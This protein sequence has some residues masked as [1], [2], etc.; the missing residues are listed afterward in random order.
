MPTNIPGATNQ[1]LHGVSHAFMIAI[2]VLILGVVA[3]FFF[4]HRVAP[5]PAYNPK[6]FAM[7]GVN[8]NWYK[9]PYTA[10]PS[11]APT[12]APVAPAAAHVFVPA[13]VE[14]PSAAATPNLAAQ[15]RAR[16]LMRAMSSDFDVKI[17]GANV[18][19]MPEHEARR[20]TVAPKPAPPHTLTAWSYLYAVLETGISSDHPGDVIARLSQDA[21]DSV[22]QTEILI[23][24]GSKLHGIE[25]GS[26]QVGINDRS[27]I[28]TWDDLTLPNG[29]HVPLPRL[30]AA[31]AQGYPGLTDEVDRHLPSTW[32]PA[33]LISSITAGVMLAQHPTFGSYQGY[34]ASQQASGAFASTLGNH[35]TQALNNDLVI[36]RPTIVIRPGTPFRVLLTH[37]LTFPGPY[38]G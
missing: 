33:L 20:L 10:P 21:R 32:G 9:G 1:Q 15:E 27:I 23:P 29:G 3:G 37:D 2:A 8:P 28:V 31:D 17:A 34:D 25:R 35:A 36:S 13:Q 4:S 12:L 22:A 24:I 30:P 6:D 16:S 18:L 38:G 11:A 26:G 5:A 7:N 14:R 19:D